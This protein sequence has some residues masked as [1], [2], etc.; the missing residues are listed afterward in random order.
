MSDP[1]SLEITTNA[2]PPERDRIPA[3]SIPESSSGAAA[4]TDAA[5]SDGRGLALVAAGTSVAI[6]GSAIVVGPA[7]APTTLSKAPPD[8]Q[9]ADT[10]A[11]VMARVM[12]Q[13]IGRMRLAA[14]GA[15]AGEPQAVKDMRVATRRLRTALRLLG[16]YLPPVPRKPAR[17]LRALA[18]ALGATRGEDVFL[19]GVDTFLTEAGRAADEA[20]AALRAE[21]L[22][23]RAAAHAALTKRLAGAQGAWLDDL[24]TWGLALPERRP[25]DPD[26][27]V[28]QV[29]H[30]A[31]V[32]IWQ[33]YAEVRSYE[34]ILDH[35]SVEALHQLRLTGKRLRYALEFFRQPLGEPAKPL[36]Q[37]LVAQQDHLGELNDLDLAVSEL[38]RFLLRWERHRRRATASPGTVVAYLL[39]CEDRRR[40]LV[41]RVLAVAG[42]LA[43]PPF[44][45]ALAS[46]LAGL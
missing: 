33:A 1:D 25:A 5:A 44:R 8:I 19:A 39:A 41:E 12:E 26:V 9:P 42:P 13:Q 28:P 45:Q 14:E 23:A 11:A 34:T 17:N 7:P 30:L 15:V 16:P 35:A 6:D 4:P 37:A 46:A 40:D 36:I 38:G 2:A 32:L 27:P 24:E 31:P 20:V 18:D 3:A 21:R 22:A 43:E 29:R 10:L